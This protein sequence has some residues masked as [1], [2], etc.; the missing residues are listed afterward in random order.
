M[1]THGKTLVVAMIACMIASTSGAAE[2]AENPFLKLGIDHLNDMDY[3]KA[4][5]ILQ[6]ALDWEGNTNEAKAR[7][8]M[9]VGI[10]QIHMFEVDAAE[11][12]FRRALKLN[13][14][15]ALPKGVSPKISEVFARVSPEPG[16]ASRPATE[17]TLPAGTIAGST[18]STS[19]QTERRRSYYSY[20]TLITLGGAVAAAGAGLTLGLL[21]NSDGDRAMDT[22]T[23][24][25]EANE[26]YD[27][28]SRKAMAANIMFGVAGAA[29][30]A[31]GVLFYFWKRKPTRP[32]TE[33]VATPNGALINFV[34]EH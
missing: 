27:S 8:H 3:G 10:T 33:V 2:P 13:P 22:S 25:P 19:A 4:F 1:R 23:S 11:K 7:V 17:G 26:A 6:R 15:L 5:I 18:K 24:W 28:G 21:A 14:Q 16:S 20:A 30:V 9:Y 12:S 31:S 34:Y 32:A 29:A